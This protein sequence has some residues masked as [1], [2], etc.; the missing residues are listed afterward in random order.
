[1]R[2]VS[3]HI[4]GANAPS[5]SGISSHDG[6]FPTVLSAPSSNDRHPCREQESCQPHLLTIRND[7]R[8][9]ST[10]CFDRMR[11]VTSSG[12]AEVG[13]EPILS[14]RACGPTG[15]PHLAEIDLANC[16]LQSTH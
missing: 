5:A 12:H 13:T 8:S 4:H 16:L 7:L 15:Y 9:T 2:L 11:A 14:S 1:M 3:P 10:K 6:A